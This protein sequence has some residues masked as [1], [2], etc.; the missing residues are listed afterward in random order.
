[1]LIF[2]PYIPVIRYKTDIEAMKLKIPG[3]YFVQFGV[4][5]IAWDKFSGKIS[6]TFKVTR[7]RILSGSHII[8]L[9]KGI[10]NFSSVRDKFNFL[11]I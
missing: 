6:F 4:Q 9:N 10:L 5:I 2:S 8:K 3:A 11:V 7:T 1:M